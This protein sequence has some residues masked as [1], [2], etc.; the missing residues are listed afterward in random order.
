MLS[1][2]TDTGPGLV[3]A[4]RVC[5]VQAFAP[6]AATKARKARILLAERPLAFMVAVAKGPALSKKPLEPVQ[7]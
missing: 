5:T 2:E 6:L 3:G 7:T 4:R 1:E